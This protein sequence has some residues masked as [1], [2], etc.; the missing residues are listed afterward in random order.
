LEGGLG[1]WTDGQTTTT[2]RTPYSIAV[3]RQKQQN[4]VLNFKVV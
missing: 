3:A 1:G 4:L 2:P